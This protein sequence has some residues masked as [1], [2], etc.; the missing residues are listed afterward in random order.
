MTQDYLRN[1]ACLAWRNSR[2]AEQKVFYNVSPDIFTC[3]KE[4]SQRD[5]GTK[6][7]Y[8]KDNPN[9]G[10]ST[11]IG[12]KFGIKYTVKLGFIH[13]LDKR[14]LTYTEILI[15]NAQNSSVWS[16]IQDAI[17]SCRKRA[18]AK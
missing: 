3:M 11:T 2:M 15:K 16:G 1:A 14:I 18:K 5:H 8:D 12:R 10:T 17:D 6:Y 9:S 7:D 13:D 4:D